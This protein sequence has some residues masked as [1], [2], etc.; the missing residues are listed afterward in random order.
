MAYGGQG[1]VM[2]EATGQGS[3]VK[4]FSEWLDF[5]NTAAIDL[6]VEI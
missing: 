6:G 4:K 1:L 5:L 3:L 2:L